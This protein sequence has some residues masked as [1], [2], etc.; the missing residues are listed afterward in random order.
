MSPQTALRRA[1]HPAAQP[2]LRLWRGRSPWGAFRSHLEVSCNPD[3]GADSCCA[4]STCLKTNARA[5]WSSGALRGLGS[6]AAQ[7]GSHTGRLT[8]RTLEWDV[9]ET[10]PEG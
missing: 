4:C 6:L 5:M 10:V 2:L 7:G 8:A 1:A 3:E 9:Q